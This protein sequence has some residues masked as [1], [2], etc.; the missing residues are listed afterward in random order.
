[1]APLE[2]AAVQKQVFLPSPIVTVVDALKS[3]WSASLQGS[4]EPT[5]GLDSYTHSYQRHQRRSALP[6]LSRSGT[7]K[8]PSSLGFV[9]IGQ[10]TRQWPPFCIF[11]S[12][13]EEGSSDFIY[14]L[15]CP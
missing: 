4:S 14:F 8:P 15:P 5:H 3:S 13:L 11:I 9:A 1:V 12:F 7:A 10:L 6:S 2:P